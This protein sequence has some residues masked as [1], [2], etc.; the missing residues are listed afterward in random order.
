MQVTCATAR[1]GRENNKIFKRCEHY[2]RR[3]IT[4]MR[5]INWDIITGFWIGIAVLSLIGIAR[6]ALNQT[7]YQYDWLILVFSLVMLLLTLIFKKRS[8]Y[9]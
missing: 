7:L 2:T 3:E 1:P 5:K 6:T 8:A 4:T 9:P